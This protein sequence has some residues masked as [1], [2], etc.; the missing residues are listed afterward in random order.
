MME[1]QKADRGAFGF[2]RQIEESGKYLDFN[3]A[4]RKSFG[5]SAILQAAMSMRAW[6]VAWRF[7]MPRP[8]SFFGVHISFQALRQSDL[9]L[10]SSRTPVHQKVLIMAMSLAINFLEKRILDM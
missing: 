3:T 9:A 1:A 7:L 2:G 8:P 4:W 6:F 5:C 10:A